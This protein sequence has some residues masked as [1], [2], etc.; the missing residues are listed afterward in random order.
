MNGRAK[1]TETRIEGKEKGARIK[2]EDRRG[3]P[4]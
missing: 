2:N 1:W 3:R 4:Q